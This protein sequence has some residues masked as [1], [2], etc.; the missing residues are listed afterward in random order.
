METAEPEP[1]TEAWA[2]SVLPRRE[3]GA[4]KWGVG[5][6]VV[7]AGSPQFAGAAALCCAGAGRSGAGIVVA[8]LPRS[9]APVVVG[10]VPEATVVF[11]PD[12][13]S[14][15]VAARAVEAIAERLQRAGS[16]VVGPGL[17]DDEATENLL[18]ALFGAPKNRVDI[19]FGLPNRPGEPDAGA[20]TV[21]ASDRPVVVDADA[22]NWLAGREG[23]WEHLPQER[24]VLTPHAG[25]MARLVKR[26]S[27]EIVAN[28]A[29]VARDAA[30][31]WGQTVVLKGSP[32]LVASPDGRLVSA[33]TPASLATAG[34]GDVLSGSIAAFLAQGLSPADAAALAV[35]VGSRAAARLAERYGTLGIVAG[36]L[37]VAIAEELGALERMGG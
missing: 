32:T 23:W 33:P 26:E 29:V 31:T 22:L 6:V 3:P 10:L 28:A 18:G 9:V 7:V 1:I 4:H 35:V 36:D 2:A 16:M 19:G 8:A 12:G 20:G 5:G 17:G 27:Q 37:P 25:E 34:S 14:L 21:A 13:D 30:S 15:S 11:L 24:L